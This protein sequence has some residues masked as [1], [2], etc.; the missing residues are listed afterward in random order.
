[1]FQLANAIEI[2]NKA[3]YDL[4]LVNFTSTIRSIKRNWNLNCFGFEPSNISNLKKLQ[5]FD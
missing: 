1:M 2:S 4:K 5:K 3:N